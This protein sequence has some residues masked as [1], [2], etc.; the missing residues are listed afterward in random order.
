M[1]LGLTII[2]VDEF[3][4]RTRAFR[5]GDNWVAPS[6]QN[7]INKDAGQGVLRVRGIHD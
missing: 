6:G 5:D 1:G 3:G 2:W 4:E 7:L